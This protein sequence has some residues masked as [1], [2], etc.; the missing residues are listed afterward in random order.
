M[1][2]VDDIEARFA[3][4]TGSVLPMIV[5]SPEKR[6]SQSAWLMIATGARSRYSSSRNARPIAGRRFSA[7]KYPA[8]IHAPVTVSATDSPASVKPSR[9]Q[10]GVASKS[11]E[12]ALAQSTFRNGGVERFVVLM[13]A[14]NINRFDDSYGSGRIRYACKTP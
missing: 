4:R 13:G 3:D 10:R 2:I 12:S 11:A 1:V 6:R 7:L 14:R 9:S 5:E 8:D